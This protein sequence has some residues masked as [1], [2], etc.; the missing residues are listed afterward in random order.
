MQFSALI[1]SLPPLRVNTQRTQMFLI[2]LIDLMIK[3]LFHEQTSKMI[4]HL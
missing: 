3:L 4:D 1:E 2:S